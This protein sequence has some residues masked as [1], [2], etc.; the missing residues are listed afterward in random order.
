MA[1]D[2]TDTRGWAFEAEILQAILMQM[3]AQKAGVSH[4]TS[5][6]LSDGDILLFWHNWKIHLWPKDAFHLVNTPT[7]LD[8]IIFVLAEEGSGQFRL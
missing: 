4:I 8:D 2:C 5:A 7:K 3:P 6:G 1:S